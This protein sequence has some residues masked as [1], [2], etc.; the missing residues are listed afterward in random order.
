MSKFIKG[1][2]FKITFLNINC[3]YRRWW[4]LVLQ[5][6]FFTNVELIWSSCKKFWFSFKN[7]KILC[8]KLN[9]IFIRHLEH[10]RWI[11]I[12]TILVFIWFLN[13]HRFFT[14]TTFIEFQI[15]DLGFCFFFDDREVWF[16]NNYWGHFL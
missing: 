11:Y 5:G 8:W 3:W 10:L 7:I 14:L 4:H 6:L 12:L 2:L 9:W 15:R 1:N 13:F 16:I